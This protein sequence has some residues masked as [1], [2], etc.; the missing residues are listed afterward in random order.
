MATLRKHMTPDMFV[1]ILIV[2]TQLL[3][4]ADGTTSQGLINTTLKLVRG[5]LHR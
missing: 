3:Q 2:P 4:F 5:L 1:T